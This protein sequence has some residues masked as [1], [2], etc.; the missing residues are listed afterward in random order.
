VVAED[1]GLLPVGSQFTLGRW[2]T[3][4]SI[5][6]G[7]RQVAIRTYTE[8]YFF[9][10]TA[11]EALEPDG[12]PCWLGTREPQGEGLAYLDDSTLVLTSEALGAQH[13]MI[14]RVRC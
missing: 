3:A 14:H 13:G 7:T 11:T 4:A 5:A 6:P 1:L 2:V 9:R 8:I 12:A 10:L